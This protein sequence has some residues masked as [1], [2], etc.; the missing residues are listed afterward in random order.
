MNLLLTIPIL[1]RGF[2]MQG[3]SHAKAA[4]RRNA[5]QNFP[6][7]AL[8]DVDIRRELDTRPLR[9]PDYEREHEAFGL[10]AAELACNPHNMLQ[11]LAEVA[12]DLCGAHT[13]GISLLEG[14]LFRWEAVAGVFAS[15]RGGTMP[16]NASPC[17]VCIDRDST[18]LMSL[19]DRCFPSLYAEPRFVEALLIPFHDRG[20]AIGTVWI[21][22][23]SA[24]RRF[25]REDERIVR[26][27]A[28]YASAGWQLWKAYDA[29]AEA[30]RRKERLLATLG[31][32]LRNPLAAITAATAIL[33]QQVAAG[34]AARAVEVISRQTRLVE[35][36]AGDLLDSSRL[37]SGKL[38]LEITPL[39]LWR[40][41]AEAVD[42]CRPKLQQRKLDVLVELPE[43]AAIVDGDPLRLAQVFSNLIDNA[44]KFTPEGG[45]VTIGGAM[46]A[47]HAS[48][49][50]RDT[51]EGIPRDQ[52]HRIFEPFAQLHDL[53][54]ATTSSGL[55]LGL[56]LVRSLAELHGGTVTVT[57]DGVGQ[58]S[59]FT[60]RMPVPAQREAAS[61]RLANVS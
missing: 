36:L 7:A 14:D 5:P 29:A 3:S 17:G 54:D 24:D 11:K 21:V 15:A 32:E 45:R 22:S 19:P 61:P 1:S 59:C 55:G 23:H 52:I 10:L 35:R 39:D 26:I 58:G 33:E 13:A 49:W 46:D 37:G 9:S 60:V 50:I 4:S 42:T 57:S 2:D 12:V 27:L 44:A 31:H 34:S 16:R 48:V 28:R 8:A 47:I 30:N 56:S 25:D 41:V 40:I 38:R 6:I 43:D 51:G 20:R 53:H 18:Q